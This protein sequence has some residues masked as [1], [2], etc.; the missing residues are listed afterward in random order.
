[1]M[2]CGCGS[3]I[4]HSG[5]SYSGIESSSLLTKTRPSGSLIDTWPAESPD[6]YSNLVSILLSTSKTF[7]Y[8]V[9][10]SLTLFILLNEYFRHF[11]TAL[12]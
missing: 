2:D 3:I 9:D 1:M 8:F 5:E 10:R 7:P 11:C 12:S 4:G 6:K